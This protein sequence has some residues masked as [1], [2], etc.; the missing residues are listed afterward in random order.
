M[1]KRTPQEREK[2]QPSY[3]TTI[4]SEVS[5]LRPW[6]VRPYKHETR[7]NT[8]RYAASVS[9]RGGGISML[10]SW[11][12]FCKVAGK[13]PCWCFSL[14][15]A[16]VYNIANHFLNHALIGMNVYHSNSPFRFATISFLG[17]KCEALHIIFE[18]INIFNLQCRTTEE[19]QRN[20]ANTH[21]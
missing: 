7:L 3:D 13:E 12:Y 11:I 17:P 20:A 21:I 18:N 8:N 14:C 16:N 15:T 10:V 4:L 5:M 9:F 1:E 2:Y 19:K 6:T